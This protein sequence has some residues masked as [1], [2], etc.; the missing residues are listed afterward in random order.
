M[1]KCLAIDDEPLALDLLQDNIQRVPFL[2]LVKTCKN[3]VEA[4]QVLKKE[5]IDLMFLDVQMP[6]VS[7]I[8][9]LESMK[10]PPLAIFI[11]AHKKFALEGFNLD[12]VDYLLKP[13]EFNRF[14]KA[15]TKAY[16]ILVQK[17]SLTPLPKYL[18]VNADYNLVKVD[19][20]DI[21]YVEGSK[22]YVKIFLSSVGKPLVTR[23]SM[24]A[25]EGKLPVSLFIRVHK[26]FIV[27]I[28][29]M[30]SIRRGKIAISS[31]HI[32]VS[33]RYRANLNMVIDSELLN[34]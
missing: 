18:F 28:D 1:I 9:F 31:V 16:E 13:V 30:V 23:I 27:S 12:A 20:S 11:T 29:K 34:G 2:H 5:K 7:G 24:K 25:L 4:S 6:G 10:T 15:A 21:L 8:Q 32:P 26:S 33:K 22:D 19:L 17:K 14:L 3:T